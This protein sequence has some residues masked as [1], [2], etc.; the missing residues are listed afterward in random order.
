MLYVPANPEILTLL[1]DDL[2]HFM[3]ALQCMVGDTVTKHDDTEE[4]LQIIC[5]VLLARMGLHVKVTNLN[6]MSAGFCSCIMG[7]LSCLLTLTCSP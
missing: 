7:L 4:S 3:Q 1:S 5:R 2:L 6:R